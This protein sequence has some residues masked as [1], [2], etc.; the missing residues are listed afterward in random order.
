MRVLLWGALGYSRFIECVTAY[1]MNVN[2]IF[3][4]EGRK[5]FEVEIFF[6]IYQS[7]MFIHGSTI[8]LENQNV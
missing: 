4:F 3:W 6:L 8:T 2:E 1:A 5:I 7:I